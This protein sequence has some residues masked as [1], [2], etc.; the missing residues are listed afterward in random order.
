MN[1]PPSKYWQ[2]LELALAD[3]DEIVKDPNYVIDM[4]TYHKG[5]PNTKCHICLAGSVMARTL[6]CDKRDNVS[7]LA[8]PKWGPALCDISNMALGAEPRFF[9]EE[10]REKFLEFQIPIQNTPYATDPAHWRA[11]MD[12][13]VQWLKE[14]DF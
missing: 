5:K 12:K 6:H 7:P 1:N 3:F 2:L 4:L 8:L 10:H 11:H 13:V 9:P 14:R